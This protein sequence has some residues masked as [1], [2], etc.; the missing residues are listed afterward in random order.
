MPTNSLAMYQLI[1]LCDAAAHTAPMLP[2]SVRQ[3]HEVMQIHVACRAKD[4]PRK[5]S[6]QDVLVEAGRMVLSTS[7]PR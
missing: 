7:K 3:A 4:C 2:F 5:A 6:A 1:A